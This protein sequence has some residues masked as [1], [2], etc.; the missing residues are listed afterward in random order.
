MLS[1][2]F[3]W[4]SL[5]AVETVIYVSVWLQLKQ[6]SVLSAKKAHEEPD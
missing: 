4:K 2:G 1:R 3:D 5:N 6:S